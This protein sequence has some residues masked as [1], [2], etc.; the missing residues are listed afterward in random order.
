[1]SPSSAPTTA[2]LLIIGAEVLSGKVEDQ[3]GPFLI[4]SLRERGIDLKEIRIIDDNPSIIASAVSELHQNHTYLFTT[5]GIGPTHDDVT[6]ASVAA[7]FSLPLIE[8]P[9]LASMF[10]ER[11]REPERQEAALRMARIPTGATVTMGGFVPIVR[12]HN[13]ILFPGVPSLLRACFDAISPTLRGAP[14]FTD[15]LYLNTSE[16]NIAA[17]LTEI[18]REFPQV[19]IGSYPQFGDEK[20]RVKVTVDSRDCGAVD[21]AIKRIRSCLNSSWFLE[22]IS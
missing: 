19:A 6:V 7:A 5:G 2:A 9:T 18:Q 11:F 10:K 13:I 3:N 22:S 20:Y 4:R 16:T 17:H 14:F 1:M 8:D 21:E 15:A 12:L